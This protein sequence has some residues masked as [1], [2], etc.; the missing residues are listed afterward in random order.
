M[1]SGARKRQPS[2]SRPRNDAHE[3]RYMTERYESTESVHR[4]VRVGASKRDSGGFGKTVGA[5]TGTASL[6]D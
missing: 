6:H 5:R 4:P 2:E 1:S 3:R